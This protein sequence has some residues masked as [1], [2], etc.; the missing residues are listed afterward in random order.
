MRAAPLA[1]T[2][3]VPV[4]PGMDEVPEFIVPVDGMPV[5]PMEVSVDPAPVLPIV[6][7]GAVPVLP[8]LGWVVVPALVLPLPAVL[9]PGGR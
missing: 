2:A 7:V 5:V 8:G 9:L 3:P 1:G 4:A 6:P